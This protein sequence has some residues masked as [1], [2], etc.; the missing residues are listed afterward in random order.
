MSFLVDVARLVESAVL[1][2]GMVLVVALV[3]GAAWWQRC[4][5]DAIRSSV[6]SR[7]RVER[8]ADDFALWE[9]ELR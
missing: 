3:A 1:I 5:A 2:V 4:A 9:R 8:P 6:T 7:P